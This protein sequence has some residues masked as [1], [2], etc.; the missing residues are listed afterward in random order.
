[1]PVQDTLLEFYQLSNLCFN[2]KFPPTHGKSHSKKFPNEMAKEKF[3]VSHQNL[4]SHKYSVLSL[5]F[6][7]IYF[8]I[9]FRISTTVSKYQFVRVCIF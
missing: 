4:P 7:R 3:D 1:M 9:Q 5:I 8:E 2:S 6:L